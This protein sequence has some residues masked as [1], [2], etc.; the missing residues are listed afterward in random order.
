[1]NLINTTLVHK[2]IP[3]YKKEGERS[4]AV[5]MLHGRGA[6]E[7][8]LLGLSEYLDERFFFIAA[9]APYNFQ[10]GGGYTWYDILEIGKP[11]PKMFGDSYRR[12]GEF[13][14]DVKKGYPIDPSRIFLFGFSMGTIMAFALALTKPGMVRGVIANSG[15]IPEETDLTFQWDKLAGTSFFVAHGIDDPVI[16]VSYGRRAKILLDYAKADFIYHEY[17]MAHQIT[18]ESLNDI[19]KWL[20]KKLNGK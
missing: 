18:E 11:E 3:P 15:Y 20:V 2:I 1:M 4:P 9:R 16:P 17:E 8:D 12:L 5:I 19:G 13:F 14:E 10:F 6:S 7:D